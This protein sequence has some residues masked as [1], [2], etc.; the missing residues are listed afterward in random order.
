MRIVRLGIIGLGYVGLIHLRHLKH[1]PNAEIR[2]VAD[3][4]TKALNKAKTIGAK[5]GVY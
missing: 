5:K 1:L 3:V 4:S 2:A